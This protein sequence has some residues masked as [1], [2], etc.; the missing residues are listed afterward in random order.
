V[1]EK[2]AKECGFM[3]KSKKTKM[4]IIQR[5]ERIYALK[6]FLTPRQNVMGS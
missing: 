5:S 2:M 4:K 6:E 3:R 1:G